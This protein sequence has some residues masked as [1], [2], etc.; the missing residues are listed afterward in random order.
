MHRARD[1]DTAASAGI[2]V[3]EWAW[4]E[5][6]SN[7]DTYVS[8]WYVATIKF[9]DFDRQQGTL[10]EDILILFKSNRPGCHSFSSAS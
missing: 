9:R 8:P 5:G 2:A 3:P 4:I 10:A 7:T 1:D 6:G